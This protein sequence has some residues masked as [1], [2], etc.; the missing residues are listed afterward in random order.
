MLTRA[1]FHASIHGVMKSPNRARAYSSAPN[2]VRRASMSTMTPISPQR[3]WGH[4][5]GSLSRTLVPTRRSIIRR[6]PAG[7]MSSMRSAP[8]K[9]SPAVVGR[10]ASANRVFEKPGDYCGQG[11][12]ADQH[13]VADEVAPEHSQAP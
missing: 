13:N 12:L 5:Y 2:V 3:T 9:K 1:N 7:V 11:N 10:A 4:W 8:L 6:S